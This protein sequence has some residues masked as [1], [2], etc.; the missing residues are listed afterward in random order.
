[1]RET[2]PAGFEEPLRLYFEALNKGGTQPEPAA[3]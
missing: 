1:M 3:K 2:D